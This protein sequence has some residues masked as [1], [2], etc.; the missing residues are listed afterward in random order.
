MNNLELATMIEN[1]WMA[2]N[3]AVVNRLHPEQFKKQLANIMINN[4][5]DIIRALR[6]PDEQPKTEVETVVTGDEATKT[7]KVK[8]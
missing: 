8:K 2:Y 7:K 6:K 5:S 4:A 3:A 1:A